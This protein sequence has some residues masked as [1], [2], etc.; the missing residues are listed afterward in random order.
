[1]ASRNLMREVPEKKKRIFQSILSCPQ[2]SLARNKSFTLE[3]LPGG[4]DG[5]NQSI[6]DQISF[7]S[8]PPFLVKMPLNQKKNKSEEF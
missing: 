5:V 1:M 8:V 3:L 2:K 7:S 6:N 4:R